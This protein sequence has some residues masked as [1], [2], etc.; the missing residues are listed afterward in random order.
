M[1][2]SG[3]KQLLI[4]IAV[5]AI[6]AATDFVASEPAAEGAGE[7]ERSPIYGIAIPE[8]YRRWEVVAPSQEAGTLNELRVI[9]GNAIAIKAY[10]DR[11]LRFPDGAMLAKLAWK[12]LPSTGD[13]AALGSPQAF[14]PG[15]ATTVQIMVKDSQKY[16]TTGGWGFGRFIGGKSVDEAQHETCFPCHEAHAAGRDFLLTLYAH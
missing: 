16:T 15:V 10:R 13:D 8:G 5:L 2:T 12:R 11:T 4:W 14:V 6:A 9:L 1:I 7:G 3:K